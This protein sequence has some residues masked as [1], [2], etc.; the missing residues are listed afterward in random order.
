MKIR[1]PIAREGWP[2]IFIGLIVVIISIILGSKWLAIIF[3]I[4]TLCVA[5]FFRDPERKIRQDDRMILSPA[6]GRILQILPLKPQGNGS[7]YTQQVSIFMSV[8]NCHINR[9]PLSG[10]VVRCEYHPGKFLPAFQ[11]KASD[12]NEKNTVYLENDRMA[13]GIRQ[14]AGLIARRIVCRVKPGDMVRQG[15]RF[16]LIRF[17]S[18]VD[19]LLPSHTQIIVSPGQ[20]VKAGLS[21]IAQFK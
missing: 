14:I 15:N 20:K 2:F 10:K 17:G 4:I 21:P 13:I 3:G 5:L 11:D 6:D 19:L 8:F 12:L 9:V 18:R 1:I 7:S 16:G